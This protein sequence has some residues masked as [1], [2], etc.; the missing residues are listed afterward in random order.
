MKTLSF[1]LPDHLDRELTQ[2]ARRQGTTKSA[3]IRESLEGYLFSSLET[4]EESLLA[5]AGDLVGCLEGP[6]DLSV[7]GCLDPADRAALHREL[8]ASEE[9]LG[10]G[11]LVD[12][13]E[14][15]KTLRSS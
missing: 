13:E 10:A 7:S 15:L 8:V 4:S 3:L 11:H 12:A 5:L 9:D 6:G 2:R 1:K 14:V